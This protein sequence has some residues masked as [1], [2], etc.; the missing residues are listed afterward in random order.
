M[1]DELFA[2]S[3]CALQ[4]KLDLLMQIRPNDDSGAH[5]DFTLLHSSG[6]ELGSSFGD[7][8]SEADSES[9]SLSQIKTETACPSLYLRSRHIWALNSN[10]THTHTHTHDQAIR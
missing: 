3:L 9:G 7:T 5:G 10:R 6:S 8:D 1:L 4:M 2:V